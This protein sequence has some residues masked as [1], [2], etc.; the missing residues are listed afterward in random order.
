MAVGK[1]FYR[2]RDESS[3]CSF[4]GPEL[5]RSGIVVPRAWSLRMT[6]LKM[7]PDCRS[8]LYAGVSLLARLGG[9]SK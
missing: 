1:D 6:C 2:M 4:L 5:L 3:F 8:T 7:R 9:L